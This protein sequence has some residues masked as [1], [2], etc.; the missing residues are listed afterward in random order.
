VGTFAGSDWFRSRPRALG[1][2]ATFGLAPASKFDLAGQNPPFYDGS[3]MQAMM[4]PELKQLLDQRFA[5]WKKIAGRKSI[6]VRELAEAI[7]SSTGVRIMYSS[8]HDWR[9]GKAKPHS[10]KIDALSKF[11]APDDAR[12]QEQI[13]DAIQNATRISESS[14]D[15]LDIG[16]PLRVGIVPFHHFCKL[17]ESSSP[18]GFLDTLVKHFLS[19]ASLEEKGKAEFFPI[20]IAEVEKKLC[21]T[22][23]IDIVLGLFVDPS[24]TQRLWFYHD[25][26]ILIPLNAVRARPLANGKTRDTLLEAMTKPNNREVGKSIIPIIDPG[27]LGGIYV[28]NYLGIEEFCKI[29]Y[30]EETYVTELR[31][32]S[33]DDDVS[34]LPVCVTDEVSCAYIRR[35]T[36]EKYRIAHS[37][38]ASMEVEIIANSEK[39]R[40][41]HLFPR[42]RYG[43]ALA[44][45]HLRWVRFFEECFE[46]FLETNTELVSRLYGRLYLDLLRDMQNP[47]LKM[48]GKLVQEWLSKPEKDGFPRRRV[49]PTWQAILHGVQWEEHNSEISVGRT[50][51]KASKRK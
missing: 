34:R 11:F 30:E 39:A 32:L 49:S 43:F 22:G 7:T 51:A 13:K 18:A 24:R 20:K 29:S 48:A 8:L 1:F 21:E 14:V 2:V 40:D 41:Q 10:S 28:R 23:D 6:S 19:F 12:A 3:H 50:P 9:S 47:P 35:I 15:P 45:K 25:L 5:E 38:A 31:R 27:E 37:T 44:R 26:P 36:R 33:E 16:R 42:Y 17:D 46:L 4:Y